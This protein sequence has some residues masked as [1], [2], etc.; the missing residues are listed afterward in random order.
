MNGGACVCG[1][2][3]NRGFYVLVIND[4]NNFAPFL[5]ASINVVW[6]YQSIH[7]IYIYI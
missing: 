5:S 3:S 2:V 6:I 1:T 7:L 4:Y